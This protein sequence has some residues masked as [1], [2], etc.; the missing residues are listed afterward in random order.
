VPGP[1]VSNYMNNSINTGY[2]DSNVEEKNKLMN[3][4]KMDNN[5]LDEKIAESKEKVKIIKTHTKKN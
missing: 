4:I 5:L 1:E 2:Y 3:I